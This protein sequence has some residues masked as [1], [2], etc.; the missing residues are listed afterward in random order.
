[1]GLPARSSSVQQ[2]VAMTLMNDLDLL[3]TI[4]PDRADTISFFDNADVESELESLSSEFADFY[5]E[6]GMPYVH[7]LFG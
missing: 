5:F 1:M 4:P 2:L 3:E 6:Y 7:Y